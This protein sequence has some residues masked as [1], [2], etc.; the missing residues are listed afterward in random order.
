MDHAAPG[1]AAWSHAM[2]GLTARR[3]GRGPGSDA[4]SVCAIE[5]LEV[6]LWYQ[7][8]PTTQEKYA[9]A[10][11]ERTH[12][13]RLC[14]SFKATKSSPQKGDNTEHTHPTSDTESL[15]ELV[16]PQAVPLLRVASEPCLNGGVLL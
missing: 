12:I 11:H 15:V 7:S 3:S 4:T 13:Y 5:F 16:E 14:I 2:T 1:T 9:Y 6:Y 10:F 8:P